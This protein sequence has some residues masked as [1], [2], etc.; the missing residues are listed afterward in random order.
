MTRRRRAAGWIGRA[1]A[2]ALAGV[3]ALGAVGRA[4][5]A[6]GPLAT[7][8]AGPSPTVRPTWTPWPRRPTATATARATA[9][10]S[11]RLAYLPVAVSAAALPAAP[12]ATAASTA[13]APGATPRP[14]WTRW[15]TRAVTATPR[16]TLP[17]YP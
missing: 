16:P 8:T 2:L 7:V 1:S 5:A 12:V 3:L 10:P 15:P 11:G 14:T 17:G 4:R 9:R 13:A 6:P